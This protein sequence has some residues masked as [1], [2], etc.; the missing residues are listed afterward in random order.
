MDNTM[1]QIDSGRIKGVRADGVVAFKGIPF[2]QAPIGDLRWALP[3]PAA[4]WSGIRH[5]TAFG[6]GCPQTARY[7][8]TQ[9]GY[10]EDCLSINVTVPD[11]PAPSGGKRP[12]IVWIY[13]GAFVGGSSALYPLTDMALTGDAVVVSFN[14]RIGVFGFMANP[15][16]GRDHDGGYG[17]ADQRLALQWV[18]RNIATFGGDPAN[19]TVAGESAGAASICMHLASPREAAGLFAK[20]IMQSAGCTQHLRT[21]DEADLVGAKVSGLVGCDQPVLADVLACLRA[22]PV[23]DLLEAAAQVAGSDVMTYVPSITGALVEQPREAFASGRFVQ[24]PMINGGNRDELR[25]YV[26][27]AQ[28]AGN[29]P[30]SADTYAAHLKVNYGDKTDRVVAEYPAAAFSSPSAALGTALSDYTPVNGLNNCAFLETAKL[31]SAYVPVFQYEFADRAAPAVTPDPGFEMGAVHSSELP[32]QFPGFSN[33]TAL[34]GAPV[35]P[36][37]QDVARV[38][39]AYWT[40]FAATGQPR[41]ADAPTWNRFV[42]AARVMRLEPK[43][44]GDFDAG[45]EHRCGFWQKLYPEN[46][47]P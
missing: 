8:L 44:F 37:S 4:P 10:D 43:H 34:D 39:M 23:K 2:A 42:S 16:F 28:Q 47:R 38:M 21:R 24:V 9:A 19:V 3:V 45:A 32:Y 14:Y 20:A 40:S 33:T 5:A 13:G 35:P 29:P 30:V 25:L 12:V 36:G 26:A 27:Y 22:K 41:A 31:A 15:A 46:L 7:G 1:V 18:Q 11:R 17:L 6:T